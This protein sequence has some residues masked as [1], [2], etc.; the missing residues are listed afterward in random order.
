VRPGGLVG[1]SE[2]PSFEKC[3]KM[4]CGGAILSDWRLKF[5]GVRYYGFR[6]G[7]FSIPRV[8]FFTIFLAGA[9]SILFLQS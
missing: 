6:V 8:G 7:F 3:R 1:S 4:R 2:S 5:E 9:Q